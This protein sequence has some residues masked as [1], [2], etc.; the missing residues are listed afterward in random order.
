MHFMMGAT[1]GIEVNI[2]MIA[3]VKTCPLCGEYLIP[4]SKSDG[5]VS[6]YWDVCVCGYESEKQIVTMTTASS[7][8]CRLIY[9]NGGWTYEQ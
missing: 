6:T 4:F 8:N 9:E 7:T 5:N 3:I 2:V 1:G